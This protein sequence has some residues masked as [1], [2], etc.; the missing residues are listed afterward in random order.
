MLFLVLL[1]SPLLSLGLLVMTLVYVLV[2]RGHSLKNSVKVLVQG[3]VVFTCL[4]HLVFSWGFFQGLGVPDMGEECASSPRAGGH[5]PS[6]LARVDSRLF[7]P[8]TVCVWRDGMSFDLVAPYINPLLYTFLAAAVVC[9]VAAVYFR[10][11]GSRVPTKKE[12]GSGE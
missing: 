8:K 11:R 9:V 1:V 7:P 4:A 6:D 5:G 3:A 2:A 10:L 12:S